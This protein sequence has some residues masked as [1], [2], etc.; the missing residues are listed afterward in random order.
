MK[1]TTALCL[2]LTCVLATQAQSPSP[3][4]QRRFFADLTMGASIPVGRFVDKDISYANNS[5]SGLAGPG[6][7]A[8]LSAGYFFHPRLGV[9]VLAGMQWNT[10]DA[11]AYERMV[12][13]TNGDT[14]NT[15]VHARTYDW[16]VFR[17]MAG[18][19]LDLPLSPKGLFSLRVKLLAG[20]LKTAI[21]GYSY[22][23][24][25]GT[26]PQNS[27]AGMVS[28]GDRSVSLPWAFCYQAEAG[29]RI[30]ITDDIYLAGDVGW[31]QGRTFHAYHQI[32][33]N[34]NGPVLVG[35]VQEYTTAKQYYPISD[36]HAQAGVE[37]RF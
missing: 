35:N 36:L 13:Q 33:V 14:A 11:G 29:L 23:F 26:S 5:T 2:L 6:P 19:V 20:A 4:K 31:F 12:K 34:G 7:A 25:T 21:P 22:T 9:M 10:Q 1:K 18:P 17:L 32:V 30:R 16:Q 24:S 3:K 37:V 15:S 8:Q 27:S 28:M